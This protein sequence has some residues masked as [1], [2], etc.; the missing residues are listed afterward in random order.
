MMER[1]SFPRSKDVSRVTAYLFPKYCKRCNAG[2]KKPALHERKTI[3]AIFKKGYCSDS[4]K[5]KGPRINGHQVSTSKQE[6]GTR[7]N[8]ALISMLDLAVEIKKLDNKK[9][10]FATIISEVDA[11]YNMVSEKLSALELITGE[12]WS[13]GRLYFW[14]R[15]I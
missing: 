8:K 12:K 10:P 11:K 2:I 4:C 15:K 3:R 1:A 14:L 9:G 7:E 6:H 13:P 5:I